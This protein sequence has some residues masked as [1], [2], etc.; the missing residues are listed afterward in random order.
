MK[1]HIGENITL[2]ELSDVAF[3]QKNYFV[4]KFREAYNMPPMEYFAHLK[5][6]EAMKY[7]SGGE[8]RI[9]ETAKMVGISDSAYFSRFF[10][11]HTGLTP[12]EYRKLFK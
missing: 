5:T 6:Y 9:D 11:K 2:D 12:A 3:M 4:K 10:K 8:M 7:L 1:K